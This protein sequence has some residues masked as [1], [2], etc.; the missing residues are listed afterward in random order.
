[1]TTIAKIQ[2]GAMA[3]PV[4]PVEPS[5]DLSALI[6]AVQRGVPMTARDLTPALVSEARAIAGDQNANAPAQEIIIAAWVKK[7]IPLT[8]NPPTDPADSAAKISAICEICGDMPAAVW[9]PETRKAWVTQGPQGKFW[10]SPAELY[11]HLQPYADK[12]RRNIEGCRRI[13]RLAERA[14]K[15]EECV[16]AEERAA[17]ARQMAEWRKSMGHTDAEPEQRRPV[18]PQPSVSERLAECCRQLAADPTQGVWLEPLIAQLE[19]QVMATYGKETTGRA[20]S[21]AQVFAR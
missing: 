14:G 7:L 3:L 2:P 9:T 21:A 16:S 11:A 6:A 20:H 18:E 15:R 4:A 1:M 8:V 13:V 19:A 17:V 10:P 12:L 5:A